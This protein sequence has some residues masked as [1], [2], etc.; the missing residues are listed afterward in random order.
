M[1]GLS[2]YEIKSILEYVTS[3][4]RFLEQILR[5]VLCAFCLEVFFFYVR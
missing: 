3:S 2:Y 1:A 4:D 5:Y